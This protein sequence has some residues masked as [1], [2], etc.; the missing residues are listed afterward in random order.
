MSADNLLLS[1]IEPFQIKLSAIKKKRA[2]RSWTER[3]LINPVIRKSSRRRNQLSLWQKFRQ[4]IS[5]H[6]L[7]VISLLSCVLGVSVVGFSYFIRQY[8]LQ[9]IKLTAN[10]QQ[11][12]ESILEE[13]IRHSIQ[14]HVVKQQN[15]D[16]QRTAGS[17]EDNKS[18]VMPLESLPLMA[19]DVHAISEDLSRF[20]WIDQLKIVRRWPHTLEISLQEQVPAAVFNGEYWVNSRGELFAPVMKEPI[21]GLTKSGLS[22][23]I[24]VADLAKPIVLIKEVLPAKSLVSAKLAEQLPQLS[25]SLDSAEMI[26]RM[27]QQFGNL[28]RSANLSSVATNTLSNGAPR[29]QLQK[30]QQTDQLG[31]QLHLRQVTGNPQNSTSL[32]VVLDQGQPIKKLQRFLYFFDRIAEQRSQIKVV[33]VRYAHGLAVEWRAGHEMGANLAMALNPKILP[34]AQARFSH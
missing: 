3:L 22:D 14:K 13:A 8:P 30:L 24:K 16:R 32:M 33:D 23:Q 11:I 18:E 1:G 25:G 26:I 7:V 12:P 15:L 19:V 21:V 27:Y 20:V 28:L 9:E 31:W 4:R 17:A 2:R 34:A 10:F 5:A 29:L 6:T